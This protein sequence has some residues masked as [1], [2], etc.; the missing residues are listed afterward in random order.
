MVVNL[1][2]NI[3]IFVVYY[4]FERQFINMGTLKGIE[5]LISITNLLKCQKN[6]LKKS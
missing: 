1:L 4:T 5:T 2:E 6:I 3:L